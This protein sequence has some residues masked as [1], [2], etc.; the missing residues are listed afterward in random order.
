[1][2]FLFSSSF[3]RKFVGYSDN[4]WNG[5]NKTLTRIA[6]RILKLTKNEETEQIR[7]YEK[8]VSVD[9]RNRETLSKENTYL[10]STNLIQFV[11]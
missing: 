9:I 7:F 8:P 10:S 3:N 4:L 5:L 2:F 1:M 11:L 6:L